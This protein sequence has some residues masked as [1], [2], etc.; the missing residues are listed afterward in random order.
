M[1]AYLVIPKK[2]N[3]I[4]SVK[5]PR[6]KSHREFEGLDHRNF[7]WLSKRMAHGVWSTHN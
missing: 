5:T 7:F 1:K 2:K 3:Y 6:F 4:R